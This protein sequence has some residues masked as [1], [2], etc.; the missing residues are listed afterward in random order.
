MGRMWPY[1]LVAWYV[2]FLCGCGWQI[3]RGGAITKRLGMLGLG[4]GLMGVLEFCLASLADSGET[5]RHLLIF[6][7]LTGLTLWMGVTS[8]MAARA[9]TASAALPWLKRRDERRRKAA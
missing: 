2:I 4:I 8:V 5:E 3:S 7:L 9:V 6:H 1:Y